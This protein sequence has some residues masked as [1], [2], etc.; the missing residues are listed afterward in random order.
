MN[1]SP[2]IPL[3]I[4]HPRSTRYTCGL[5]AFAV[6]SLAFVPRTHAALY[7]AS[8]LLGQT[9]YTSSTATTMS[10][11]L[12]APQGVALDTANHRLFVADDGNNR[13]L[14]FALDADNNLATT[15]AAFVLG[16]TNFASSTSAT[17]QGG[18][19]GPVG[20][21]YDP[22]SQRLFVDD[23]QNNRIMVFDV[24]TSTISNGE[25]AEH[26]LGQSG[27]TTGFS[28]FTAPNQNGFWGPW[29]VAYDA[30]SQ[31]L[32]VSDIENDRVMVF[33][34]ATSTIS[35]GENAEY[36]LGQTDFL[37]SG[38]TT[39]QSGLD[40][41]R[42]MTYD[43][44]SQRLFVVDTANSRVLAF[45]AATSTI[46][47]GENAEN[48]LGQPTFVSNAATTTQSGLR[49]T[50]G[51][52][53]DNSSSQLFVADGSNRIM[54]F[55]AGTSTI[56]DGEAAE[57]VLGQADYFASSSAATQSGL[58]SPY[59]LA[60]DPTT[61]HL[62]VADESNNRVLQYSFIRLSTSSPADGTAGSS[63][64]AA[65]EAT[66]TQGTVSFGLATGSLP[67]GLALGTSTG[68]IS[69][70]P[71]AAGISSFTIEADD[72][73]TTGKFSD[74]EPFTLAIGAAPPPPPANTVIVPIPA[75]QTPSAVTPSESA[76]SSIASAPS[77]TSSTAPVSTSPIAPVLSSSSLQLE[78]ASFEAELQTLQS[79]AQEASSV[80]PSITFFRNLSLWM[81]GPDVQALQVF[82]N[83]HGFSLALSDAGSPG[84]ETNTFGLKT[85]QALIRFQEANDLPA[86]GFFG[87]LTREA[88][89]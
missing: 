24:A 71:T 39:T 29:G 82:L 70:T 47:N 32:F 81:A 48:V 88:I 34:V 8:G 72:M 20:L 61:G 33:D 42:L 80:S 86:T 9:S 83:T 60:Y 77:S 79:E 13:V 74:T 66:S 37:S 84:H 65:L 53:Y 30:I 62:F 51:V 56:T 68:I 23:F 50:E 15:T 75:G 85:Y 21:A 16:Q 40:F 25:N 11:G 63:Y 10:Q 26:V 31:R 41:P 44:S 22:V 7:N 5:V 69:G 87:P 43:P 55:D 78:L 89:K 3:R 17:T 67:P 12:R 6:L 49:S 2:F 38:A 4:L 36:V 54:I 27:F 73:F 35:D 28:N 58:H 1:M 76:S 57:N 52:A 18:L 14:V 46:A 45:D 19:W 59:G 64:S